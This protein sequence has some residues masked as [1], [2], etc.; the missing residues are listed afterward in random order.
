MCAHVCARVS[1][2]AFGLETAERSSFLLLCNLIGKIQAAARTHSLKHTRSPSKTRMLSCTTQICSICAQTGHRHM[3]LV[4]AN[5]KSAC[6]F[7]C[8]FVCVQEFSLETVATGCN[9][10]LS[11]TLEGKL[12]K[13]IFFQL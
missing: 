4:S 7:V 3:L 12:L 5:K 11:I 13:N 9:L 1:R 2:K 6:V 8:V 10:S